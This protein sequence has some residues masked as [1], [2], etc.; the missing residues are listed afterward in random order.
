MLAIIFGV[1]GDF[2]VGEPENPVHPVRIIGSIAK[3]TEKVNRRILK[4]HLK[5]AGGITWCIV[6]LITW[7]IMYFLIEGTY[8]LNFYL[9]VLISIV[10]VYFCISAK[11]LKVEGFKVLEYLRDGD[12]EGARK[13]LS[14]IV[15]RDT[16]N[17]DEEAILRAVI[18]TIAENMSDGVIAPLIYIGIGGPILGIMYKAV[19][20]MD[21]M[22]G[23]K[24][25]KYKDFGY[26]PAKLDD[27]FNF[28]PA[29]I[30]G[31]LIV[32]ACRMLKLDWRESYRIYKRDRLNHSSPNSA[33]PEAAMAGALGIQ[34]GGTNYYFGKKVVKPTIGDDLGRIR[35]SH[36]DTCVKILYLTTVLGAVLSILI[37]LLIRL[38]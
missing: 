2:I 25:D 11:G 15:G 24:N 4:N 17:L 10:F 31:L 36:F 14:Y 3:E 20:T 1:I 26:F 6:M 16:K 27:L 12:I 21:S 19:N 35:V 22:F 7:F 18:E 13:R 32:L 5:I 37:R 9:G 29:R 8:F 34:L 28:I 38:A 33:H 30:T 23:Y